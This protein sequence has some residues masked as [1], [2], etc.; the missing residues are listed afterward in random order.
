MTRGRPHPN[1]P[2]PY[3]PPPARP[4]MLAALAFGLVVVTSWDARAA[5]PTVRN[6]SRRHV[7]QA[8]SAVAV[9]PADARDVVVASNTEFGYGIFVGVSHDGGQ[10]WSRRVL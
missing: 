9:N 2:A 10:T 6:V 5:T 1:A 4:A 8:E 7:S 3:A